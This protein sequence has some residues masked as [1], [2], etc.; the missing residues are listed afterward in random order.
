[1]ICLGDVIGNSKNK[2]SE[3]FMHCEAAYARDRSLEYE[4]PGRFICCF[5]WPALLMCLLFHLKF[6][7]RGGG[8]SSLQW[9]VTVQ[10]DISFPFYGG[11]KLRFLS[12]SHSGFVSW[13]HKKVFISVWQRFRKFHHIQKRMREKVCV[14]PDFWTEVN[15]RHLAIIFLPHCNILLPCLEML[16]CEVWNIST[17]TLQNFHKSKTGGRSIV[18]VCCFWVIHKK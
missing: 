15:A 4:F 16:H 11:L 13:W 2:V 10:K 9:I 17:T 7:Q 8:G 14:Y 1:M 18:Y 5:W 6:W 3:L 12:C